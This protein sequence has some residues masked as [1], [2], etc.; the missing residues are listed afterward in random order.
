MSNEARESEAKDETV[1]TLEF[2]GHTFEVPREYDD[3]SVDFL[4][5]V[6]E[7][8]TAGIVRGAL[9]P[10]QWRTV[11][12]LDLKVRDLRELADLIAVAMGFGST[13]ESEAST[14]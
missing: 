7:G 4:E 14:G 10:V 1:A 5:S 9:G 8:K 13:G 3:L 2:R 11:K 12:S 6:E